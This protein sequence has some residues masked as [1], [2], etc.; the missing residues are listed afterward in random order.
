MKVVYRKS[1]MKRRQLL[2][3][4]PFLPVIPAIFTNSLLAVIWWSSVLLLMIAV[5][6]LQYLKKL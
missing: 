1:E 3:S 4:L 5:G 2:Y 6:W